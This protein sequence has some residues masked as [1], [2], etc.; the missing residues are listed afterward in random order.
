MKYE[1]I[2]IGVSAGGL[3]ALSEIV[4]MF[5][6]NI[7]IPVVIVQHMSPDS[8]NYLARLL[9]DISEVTVK[10]ADDKEYL[11]AGCVYIAPPDYH[12][13]INLDKT[14]FLSC[15]DRVNYS[16]P[17]VDVLFES[18]ADTFCNKAVGVV[19]T[20]ANSDGAKGLM[21]IK[22]CD[23]LGIVQAPETAQADAMPKAALEAAEVDFIVPL[24]K[25][26]RFLNTLAM[27]CDK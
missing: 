10:E 21:D 15:E 5:D 1:I 3:E 9:N 24:N 6:K 8:D 4:P 27:G 12:L 16:R 20:G 26:G 17:S 18:V 23:G 13:L 11:E 14:V 7:P 2:A 22:R 19:L 25:M